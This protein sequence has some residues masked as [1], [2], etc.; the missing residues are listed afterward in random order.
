MSAGK[1]ESALE[2]EEDRRDRIFLSEWE[3]EEWEKKQKKL[4]RKS[5]RKEGIQ[6][7]EE[8]ERL[9]NRGVWVLQEERHY[10]WLEEEYNGVKHRQ[11]R[12]RKKK[13]HLRKTGHEFIHQVFLR[14]WLISARLPRFPD[15]NPGRLCAPAH[16]G[17]PG[18]CCILFHS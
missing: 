13:N 8:E 9:D 14:A 18:V 2:R 10:Q 1:K 12:R 6:L 7:K 16:V 17:I 5:R 3:L 15:R 11:P 4:K